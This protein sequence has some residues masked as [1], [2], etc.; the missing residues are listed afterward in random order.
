MLRGT[1]RTYSLNTVK[2]L[3]NVE[4]FD[5]FHFTA[6]VLN[7]GRGMMYNGNH[8]HEMLPSYEWRIL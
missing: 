3:Y 8:N 1:K 5:L 2:V 6:C 7:D 4:N